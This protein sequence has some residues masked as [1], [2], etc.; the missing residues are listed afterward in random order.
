MNKFYFSII[1][2]LLSMTLL[3]Y[4]TVRV[5]YQYALNCIDAQEYQSAEQILS[6]MT[7]YRD[8]EPLMEY[9]KHIQMYISE[10][11]DYKG[12]FQVDE[13]KYELD[14]TSRISQMTIYSNAAEKA[15]QEARKEAA[16][17]ALIEKYGGKLPYDG[18][19]VNYLKYTSIGAPSSQKESYSGGHTYTTYYW[20]TGSG[21]CLAKCTTSS[22]GI[23]DDE[24]YNF[25]Y[26]GK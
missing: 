8:S 3:I 16:E 24:I 4:S 23:T 9:S 26:Y 19:D 11:D 10:G 5:G 18:M 14:Y 17:Q 22:R 21:E 25:E 15:V 6:M 7:F 20:T 2:L 1:V 13:L 12:Q